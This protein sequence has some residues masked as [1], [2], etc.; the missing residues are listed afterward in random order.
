MRAFE[1]WMRASA[2]FRKMDVRECAPV[3]NGCARVRFCQKWMRASALLPEMDARESASAE[4]GCARVRA[5]EK[6]MS[7]ACGKSMGV[8]FHLRKIDACDR[9]KIF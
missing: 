2:R 8:I 1:K 7:R 5:R 4:N 9:G 3:E 6:W